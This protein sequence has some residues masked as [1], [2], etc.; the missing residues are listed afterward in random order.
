[1]DDD[2]LVTLR[3]LIETT[4]EETIGPD[5]ILASDLYDQFPAIPRSTL[6]GRM[7]YLDR[8]GKIKTRKTESGR[9]VYK[10]I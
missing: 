6:R 5:E 10:V 4:L 3:M 8:L 7:E 9:L 2:R 1:M